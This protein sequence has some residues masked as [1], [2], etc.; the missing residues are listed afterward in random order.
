MIRKINNSLIKYLIAGGVAF[1]TEYSIFILLFSV[2]G[3]GVLF[4]NMLAF[5]C[6]I[7]T[8]FT[9]NRSWSFKKSVFH[10]AKTTQAVLYVMLAITNL[11]LTSFV[12]SM[13]RAIGIREEII[14]L[15]MMGAI[16]VWNF[17]IF[18]KVIFKQKAMD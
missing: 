2:I 6:G 3:I 12:L 13:S 8:S 4:A 16:V 11:G 1:V 18:N 17:L 5:A 9:L 10:Y 7:L 14:K 15:L